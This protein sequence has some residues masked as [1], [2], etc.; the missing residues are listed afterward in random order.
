MDRAGFSLIEVVMVLVIMTIVAAMA[1]PRYANAAARTRVER[2]AGR[3]VTDLALAQRRAISTGASQTV[4]FDVAASRYRIVG[5][6]HL[7]DPGREYEVLLAQAP[8][9][10]A[11]VSADFAGDTQIVFDA[12]GVPDSGGG[13]IVRVGQYQKQITVDAA[14]GWTSVP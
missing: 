5:L 1:L 10:T 6:Q 12:Y 7:D 4:V 2:A 8:Y 9:Q 3:V 13:L 14:T 11:I